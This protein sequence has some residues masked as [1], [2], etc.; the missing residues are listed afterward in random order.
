MRDKRVIRGRPSVS[1][2]EFRSRLL[3]SDSGGSPRVDS[4]GRGLQ[5]HDVAL[6]HVPCCWRFASAL[7]GN[8]LAVHAG[9]DR[10]AGPT[11]MKA[12]AEIDQPCSRD[13]VAST[14]SFPVNMKEIPFPEALVW[15]PRASGGPPSL[16]DGHSTGRPRVGISMS[17]SGESGVGAVS[18]YGSR[19]KSSADGREVGTPWRLTRRAITV[20]LCGGPP[21]PGLQN[22]AGSGL[23]L[24]T[25]RDRACPARSQSDSHIEPATKQRGGRS[26][27]EPNMPRS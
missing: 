12:M 4:L 17:R 23:P 8:P 7:A 11:E 27:P 25:L 6:N 26:T 22:H 9:P 19:S 3:S 13:A 21:C 15:T 1:R 24:R 2:W 20:P 10:L 16:L 14:S 18:S 5:A